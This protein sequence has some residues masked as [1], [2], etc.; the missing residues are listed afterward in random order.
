MRAQKLVRIGLLFGVWAYVT[1]VQVL[2]QLRG[3]GP[4]GPPTVDALCPFGGAA[5]LYKTLAG[6][7]Y[8]T[9]TW[10][11]SIILLVGTVV[12]AVL[13]RRAFCGW[14]CPLGAMQELMSTIGRK[15]GRRRGLHDSRADSALRWLKYPVLVLILAATWATGELVFRPYDPW[16]S[17]AH[18]TA[19]LDEILGEFPVG[20]AILLLSVGASLVVDRP[21][22]RYLCPLGGLLGLISRLGVTRVVRN[23]E[24]CINCRKC[25][26]ACPVDIRVQSVLQVT[27]SECLSCGECISACPVSGTLQFRAGG[28]V[29]KPVWMGIAAAVLFFAV[30]F[31]AKAAGI[32]KSR[33]DTLSEITAPEGMLDA[34]NVRGFMSVSELEE[35][36]GISGDDLLKQLNLP[37]DTDRNAAM[38]DILKPLGREVEEVRDAVA[39][40]IGGRA[41]KSPTPAGD[42]EP[43][44][45]D[46]K[47][48]HTLADVERAHHVPA[49]RIIEALGLPDTTDRSKPLRDIL[50]PSGL[51]VQAVRDVVREQR[52][53]KTGPAPTREPAD[54]RDP[55]EIRGLDTLS[56]VERS[57]GI[58][59]SRV[60]EAL[61]L[62][63]DTDVSRPLK[64][65]LK[66]QG[67]EV[68]EVRQAVRSLQEAKA[69]GGKA[70]QP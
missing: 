64:D 43:T 3:G 41:G 52:G 19:G 69:D 7:G 28:R 34:A 18:I 50:P 2:H 23:P 10:P 22:C 8:L 53:A 29:L 58:A 30:V 65:I 36:F 57:Y 31:G 44:V 48:D 54:G 11:S 51:D 27:T 68:E 35:G 45:D 4:S 61:G 33:A 24:T 46:I 25:D 26:R 14:L 9:R 15:V 17:Y 38:K 20:T 32:W 49:E 1:T 66:P 39:S 21:W 67:R 56:D 60:L 70:D 5:T 63:A 55:A 47:G 16:A 40:L 37:A 59:P 13:L 62:P 12:L 6:D 42:L